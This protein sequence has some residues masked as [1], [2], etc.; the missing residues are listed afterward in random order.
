MGSDPSSS[1]G[2]LLSIA[3][4]VHPDLGPS[5]M[6]EVAAA[7]GWPACGIWFDPASWRRA[8]TRE[9]KRRLD[10]TGVVALDVEPIIPAPDHDD[11]GERLIEIA[12]ELGAHH[13]LFTSRLPELSATIDRFAV[14]CEVAARCGV[15]LVCEFLPIFPLRSL[16]KALDVVTPHAET[17][18]GVLVDNLHLSR[19]AGTIDA[20]RA[21]DVRRLPYLQIADAPASAPTDIAGLLDEALNGRLLPGEGELP[22]GELLAAVPDVPLS[23]EVRSRA[24]REGFSDP[25]E[26]ARRLL[27]SARDL[28]AL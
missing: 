3:A 6:V 25:V 15:T 4:G 8:T 14:L 7:A 22:I 13:V 12:A 16:A 21:V 1:D 11:Q 23:F 26:R 24:L 5:R 28:S 10:D 20:V 2:R 17:V 27:A 19:S 18:A 9:V